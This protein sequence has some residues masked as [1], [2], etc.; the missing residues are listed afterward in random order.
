MPLKE[1]AKPFLEA[2][3]I[4]DLLR[5]CGFSSD[6]IYVGF[7]YVV[8]AGPDML[9]VQFESQDR[10][11]VVPAGRLVGASKISVL[12]SWQ[13]FC[14][15]VRTADQHALKRA[16]RR[17]VFGTSPVAVGVLQAKLRQHGFRL[18]RLEN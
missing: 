11:F 17:T 12:D 10:K 18:K 8:G 14:E 13:R 1:Y 15:E 16:L 3:A 2:Y 6:D 5:H 9:Y 4:F 7:D